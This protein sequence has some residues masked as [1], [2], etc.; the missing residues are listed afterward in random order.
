[1]ARARLTALALGALCLVAPGAQAQDQI[2][3]EEYGN[4]CAV[5]H[6]D[7]GTGGGTLAE[8]MTVPVP[9]L[10][11]ISERNDGAFPVQ[12]IFMIVDG[13]TGIRGHGYPMPVWGK[14]YEAEADETYGPFGAEQV[15]RARILELV[16]FLQGIQR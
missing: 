4:Y 12:K 1:M 16:F 13:R 8:I 5:C 11:K 6:G 9:D 2:G 10:T 3:A 15:V 14:R 7:D